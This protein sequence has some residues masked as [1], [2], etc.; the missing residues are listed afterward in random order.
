VAPGQDDFAVQEM[1]V[2]TTPAT[3]VDLAVTRT[4]TAS[5]GTAT[6]ANAVDSNSTT[7][8]T[9]ATGALQT[10]RVDL[11]TT[12]MVGGLSLNWAPGLHATQYRIQVSF[13]A[14]AWTTIFSTISGAAGIQALTNLSG[15]GRYV[16]VDMQQGAGT[17]YSLKDFKVFGVVSSMTYDATGGLLSTT[18]P[19]GHIGDVGIYT[20]NSPVESET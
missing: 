12:F 3:V 9:S 13:D 7:A 5:S 18:S 6:A 2:F 16:R 14:V 19:R 4:V 20:S 8:W 11:G 15:I 1:E 17:T 10:I